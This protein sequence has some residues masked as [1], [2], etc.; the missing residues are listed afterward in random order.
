M[1]QRQG[2]PQ[3]VARTPQSP[4]DAALELGGGRTAAWRLRNGSDGSQ[5]G[6]RFLRIPGTQRS[7]SPSEPSVRVSRRSSLAQH[8]CR[9][10]HPRGGVVGGGS[11]GLS[12]LAGTPCSLSASPAGLLGAWVRPELFPAA[13]SGIVQKI[14]SSSKTKTLVGRE[15]LWV[16]FLIKASFCSSCVC[17]SLQ[18]VRVPR[19]RGSRAEGWSAERP[20]PSRVE[21]MRPCPSWKGRCGRWG[22]VR[23]EGLSWGCPRDRH[24][25]EQPGGSPGPEAGGVGPAPP[26]VDSGHPP[27]PPA[28]PLKAPQVPKG[29]LLPA[30]RRPDPGEALRPLCK[31]PAAQA[32]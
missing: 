1:G 15:V 5:H 14:R 12:Q 27:V 28:C 18:R 4:V 30:T 26:G 16:Q 32:A 2:R 10:D 23:S 3:G 29:R 17:A 20:A 21:A 24:T 22:P 9:V 6:F 31:G 11:L 7:S 19:L 8:L 25:Q 13:F